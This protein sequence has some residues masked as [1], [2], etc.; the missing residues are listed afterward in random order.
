MIAPIARIIRNRRDERGYVIVYVLAL[1]AIALTL[2]A[3]V[4]AATLNSHSLTDH[5]M[6]ARRAQQAADAGVQSQLYQTAETNFGQAYNFSGGVLGLGTLLDCLPLQLDANLQIS[7]VTAYAST[8]GQCPTALLSNGTTTTSN[9]WRPIG[10]HAYYESEFF[11]NKKETN[12]SGVGSVVEFP[13]IVSIGCYTQTSS[14][15]GTTPAPSKNIYSRQ[16]VLMQPTGPVQAIEGMGNVTINGL[17]AVGINTAAVINGDVMSGGVLSLPAVGVA[18][19]TSW[20]T[21]GNPI[22]PTFGWT[23]APKP[24]TITTANLV[25]LTGFCSAAS[26][27]STC[28]IKRP[29]PLVSATT[30]GNCTTGISCASCS[31][32]GYNSSSDTFTLTGGTA[33]FAG[34]DYVFC[35]FNASGGTVSASPSS[36][37][38]VRIF[39]LPPDQAPCSAN[40]Y[41]QNVSTHAWSGGNFTAAN[42]LGNSLTGTVNGV[43][44]TLDPSGLQ[45]YV[46]GD[47]SYDNNTSV[48]LGDAATCLLKNPLTQI[49]LSGSAPAQGM[50]IYAPTSSVTV[51]TGSCLVGLLGTCTL[52]VAGTFAGSIVGDN[53]TITAAAITQDLDIGNYPIASGANSFRATQFVQCDPSVTTLSNTLSTDTSGC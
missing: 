46:E 2:G 22:L 34:G 38:P 31:G 20:P 45:I 50:V 8:A 9:F 35:N 42:G 10:N 28:M 7:G 53:V 19:N 23:T 49:C 16:L 47:G 11:T 25:Q 30:C 26:P 15:C 39:I 48:T 41:T 33:T 3:G 12:G 18:V 5:D 4:I 52:G 43:T 24:S 51:N 13:E 21:S 40:G 17:S 32:G 6:R 44:N 36:T 27:S 29:P 37:A 14:S 1:M